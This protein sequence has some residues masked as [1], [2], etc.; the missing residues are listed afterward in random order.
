MRAGD[1]P[2]LRVVESDCMCLLGVA[3]TG[4]GKRKGYGGIRQVYGGVRI[5]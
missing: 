2:G 1:S 5:L 4:G 3:E